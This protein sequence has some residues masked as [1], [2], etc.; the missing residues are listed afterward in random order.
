MNNIVEYMTEVLI[1]LFVVITFLQSG[2]DKMTDWKGNVSWLQEHFKE[3]FMGGMVPLLVGVITLLE[4]LAGGMAL[5]GIITVAISGTTLLAFYSLVIAAI[6]LLL[7]LFGQRV[8]KDYA[9]AFTI[10]GY[11]IVVVLGV[12]L[13]SWQ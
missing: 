9:G 1:L 5:V 4:L 12:F 2:I 8:A 3:T 13:L 6:T 11:F 10:V 7:L